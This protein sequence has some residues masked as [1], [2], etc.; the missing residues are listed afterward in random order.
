LAPNTAGPTVGRY[1]ARDKVNI[2]ILISGMLAR[3]G[4]DAAADWQD[5]GTSRW[6]LMI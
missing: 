2:D 1:F 4:H 5:F 6:Q 3:R